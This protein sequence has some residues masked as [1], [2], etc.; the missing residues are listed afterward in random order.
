[1]FREKEFVQ[2]IPPRMETNALLLDAVQSVLP[3]IILYNKDFTNL[4]DEMNDVN[5]FH[6]YLFGTRCNNY[7][8][9]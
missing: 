1:M 9:I 4:L 3:Y 6:S 7:N 8:L 2:P 5:I